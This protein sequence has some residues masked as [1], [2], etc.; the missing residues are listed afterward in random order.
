MG[1]CSSTPEIYIIYPPTQTPY[2]GAGILFLNG[3]LALAGIQKY[4]K[5]VENS[6]DA[7]LSGFGGRKEDSDIDWVH[8]AFREVIEELFDVSN[9]SVALINQ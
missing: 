2:K 1:T 4:R 8:T 6:V 3:P 9:V 5:V 7:Q